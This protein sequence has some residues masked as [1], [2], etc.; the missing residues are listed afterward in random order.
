MT[1]QPKKSVLYFWY[2][3]FMHIFATFCIWIV[4]PIYLFFIFLLFLITSFLYYFYRTEKVLALQY[5][6]KTKWILELYDE[7]IMPAEL[8]SSSV[9]MRYFLVL[10]FKCDDLSRKKMI[11][12]ADSFSE[13]NYRALRRCIKIGYL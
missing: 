7:K 4:S 9:M 3:I 5:D 13:E 10:H 11:L 8:L 1:F 6:K 12:F 2:L